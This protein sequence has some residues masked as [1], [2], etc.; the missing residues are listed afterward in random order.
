[1]LV[2]EAAPTL[3][4]LLGGG[5]GGGGLKDGL[6]GGIGGILGGTEGRSDDGEDPFLAVIYCTDFPK[7][8][9][10]AMQKTTPLLG[11]RSPILAGKSC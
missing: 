4:G 7:N 11:Q 10:K 9:L 3:D 2:V 1:M 8:P 5:G 6:L